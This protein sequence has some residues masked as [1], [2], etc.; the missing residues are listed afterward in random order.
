MGWAQSLGGH[1]RAFKI[2]SPASFCHVTGGVKSNLGEC[3]WGG[4]ACCN[5]PNCLGDMSSVSD[6]S[7]SMQR[8]YAKELCPAGATVPSNEARGSEGW[9]PH[10]SCT[11]LCCAAPWPLLLPGN[12][13]PS[14]MPEY[15]LANHLQQAPLVTGTSAGAFDRARSQE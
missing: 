12:M 13:L 1:F 6:M 9:S 2:Y 15:V 4:I 3:R 11:P 7:N 14:H 10:I 5:Q 8:S